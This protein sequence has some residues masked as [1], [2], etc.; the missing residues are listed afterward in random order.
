MTIAYSVKLQILF[1]MYIH[2]SID[3]FL[4]LFFS[5]GG[6]TGLD[7]PGSL[8]GFTDSHQKLLPSSP[9]SQSYSKAFPPS[10]LEMKTSKSSQIY[11]DDYNQGK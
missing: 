6:T 2:I 10:F 9:E 5:I 3:F 1:N 7:M 8:V 11:G 4:F